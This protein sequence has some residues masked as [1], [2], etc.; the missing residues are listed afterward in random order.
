ML[1]RIREFERDRTISFRTVLRYTRASQRHAGRPRKIQSARDLS[2]HL[3]NRRY[4]K[5]LATM[6][7]RQRRRIKCGPEP[8]AMQYTYHESDQS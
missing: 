4:G 2:A 3:E 7:L 5:I 6:K 1:C 8:S